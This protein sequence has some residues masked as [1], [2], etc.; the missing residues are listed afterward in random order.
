MNENEL[1]DFLMSE[2][3]KPFSGWDFSYISETG[4]VASEP[5]LWSYT[6]EILPKI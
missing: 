5:L 6:S 4:R 3:E 2:A 1:F